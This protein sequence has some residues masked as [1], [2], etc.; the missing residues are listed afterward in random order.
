MMETN[1]QFSFTHVVLAGTGGV[2]LT[3]IV[4]LILAKAGLFEKI[5]SLFGPSKG[6]QTNTPIVVQGGAIRFQSNGIDWAEGPKD[7]NGNVTQYCAGGV[8]ISRLKL[9]HVS[10]TPA[11]N[12]ITLTSDWSLQIQA[13]NSQTSGGITLSAHANQSCPYGGGG[14]PS[15]QLTPTGIGGF[16]STRDEDGDGWYNVR[17]RDMSGQLQCAGPNGNGEKGDE[18]VCERIKSIQLTVNGATNTYNCPDSRCSI[19]IGKPK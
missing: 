3:A 8:D 4:V 14:S 1:K 15:I 5:E 17:Y 18:D 2:L 10:P 13:D 19:K 11:T 7:A 16:Y 12:P 9:S 6:D